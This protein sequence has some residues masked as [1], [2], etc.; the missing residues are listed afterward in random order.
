[1]IGGAIEQFLDMEL[2]EQMIEQEAEGR[3]TIRKAAR[4]MEEQ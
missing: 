2:Y 3:E 1:M 4:L